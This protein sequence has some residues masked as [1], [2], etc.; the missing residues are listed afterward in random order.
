MNRTTYA[1]I[2]P[3]DL[4]SNY[5]NR[6]FVISIYSLVLSIRMNVFNVVKYLHVAHSS[7]NSCWLTAL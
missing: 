3:V 7:G 5:R 4:I 1:I 2:A 6:C